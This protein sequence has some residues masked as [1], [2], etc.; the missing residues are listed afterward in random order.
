MKKILISIIAL[1]SIAS[2]AENIECSGKVKL[3]QSSAPETVVLTAST[4]SL[5]ASKKGYKFDAFID[6][7]TLLLT[8]TKPIASKSNAAEE[9]SITM[10]TPE[11]GTPP[12]VLSID[13]ALRGSIELRCKF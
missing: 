6:G 4:D 12:A 10:T 2:H 5:S 7:T 11:V 8:I 13:N 1:T 9:I 3:T